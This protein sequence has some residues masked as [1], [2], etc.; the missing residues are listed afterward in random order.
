MRKDVERLIL[1]A[2]RGLENARKNIGIEAY[3]VGR[4]SWIDGWRA[5]GSVLPP[6]WEKGASGA[7]KRV[8]VAVALTLSDF[9]NSGKPG[10][11]KGWTIS[12]SDRRR[13]EL[14]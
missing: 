2:R 9:E 14:A 6:R 12:R 5:G 8:G 10:A 1:Q 3:E 4:G 7:E 11:K 13:P